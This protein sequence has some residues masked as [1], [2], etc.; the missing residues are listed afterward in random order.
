LLLRNL[1]A[2]AERCQRWS[3]ALARYAIDARPENADVLRKWIA[4]WSPRADEAVS[5][6]ARLLSSLPEKPRPLEEVRM[7]A[8]KARAA[9]LTE[10]GLYASGEAP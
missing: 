7:G 8:Q 9:L 2:D 3:R 10:S 5:S 6:L 1:R 4:I